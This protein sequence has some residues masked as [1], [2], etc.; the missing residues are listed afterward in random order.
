MYAIRSYY[1]VLGDGTATEISCWQEACV[2]RLA[3]DNAGEMNG[4]RYLAMPTRVDSMAVAIGG[5]LA[6]AAAAN[7]ASATGGVMVETTPK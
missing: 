7:E 1:A 3:I 4:A 2:A 6:I 5:V